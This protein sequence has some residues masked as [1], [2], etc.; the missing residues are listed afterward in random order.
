MHDYNAHSGTSHSWQERIASTGIH[1]QAIEDVVSSV[2]GDFSAPR[3][4]GILNA[5]FT[6]PAN[7]IKL[8]SGINAP[9]FLYWGDSPSPS[10]SPELRDY[11]LS[12]DLVETLRHQSGWYQP[13]PLPDARILADPESLKCNKERYAAFFR[14]REEANREREKNETSA[15]RQRRQSNLDQARKNVMPSQKNT[16]IKVFHW[17][18]DGFGNRNRRRLE[19]WEYE[20]YWDDD[21]KTKRRYDA[22][23]NEWDICSEF[24]DEECM[25][26]SG[27]YDEDDDDYDHFYDLNTKSVEPVQMQVL[28]P[29]SASAVSSP[30]PVPAST[31]VFSPPPAPV[32][33]PSPAPV[34]SPPP[35]LV[36]SPP[37]VPVSSPPPVPVSSRP[38]A[39]VSPPPP[40]PV[41]SRSPAPVPSR[42]PAPVSSPPP[43]PVSSHPPVSVSSPPP[44]PV[45][46]AL[47]SSIPDDSDTVHLQ[48]PD[49][50]DLQPMPDLSRAILLQ[51]HEPDMEESGVL[52]FIDHNISPSE[53]ARLL[54]GLNPRLVLPAVSLST[55]P[56][57]KKLRVDHDY[58]D[59]G[60]GQW[61]QMR[62]GTNQEYDLLKYEFGLMFQAPSLDD[63]LPDVV[64]LTD[65]R[66]P[67]FSRIG[68]SLK[69]V[70]D[71]V[72][73]GSPNY[74]LINPHASRG[75]ENLALKILSSQ[76]ILTIFR[77][78]WDDRGLPY[79]AC[80]LCRAGI[81]FRPCLMSSPQATPS[82]ETLTSGG[83]SGLGYRPKGY[84]LDEHDYHAYRLL[85]STFFQGS[86]GQLALYY[87][88]LV[89]RIALDFI[90]VD[91][92]LLLPELSSSSK[93]VSAA[94]LVFSWNELTEDDKHLICG[95][96]HV[97]AS[98]F[99][100]SDGL[101]ETHAHPRP[102]ESIRMAVM[103]AT[104]KFV[105]E[106]VL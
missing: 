102:S 76:D 58:P 77:R 15:D 91:L 22:F 69:L 19:K 46:V 57:S 88:G 54:F 75:F 62:W 55:P 2:C 49:D 41:S 6:E 3:L 28:P 89:A 9:I 67:V 11:A 70:C 52:E 65:R 16:K 43:A 24:E 8:L 61:N 66:A 36:S 32:F 78:K 27:S 29:L 84:R 83:Y 98:M 103:V 79:L 97:D 92:S 80:Q 10:L 100:L 31:S 17:D 101:S 73:D 14:R 12:S 25:L 44:A 34:S 74:F 106:R 30:P 40:V 71:N 95:V 48:E 39:L 47:P 85:L 96:Y 51:T 87:G 35:A 18:D 105:G 94:N 93:S 38:P 68:Q 13:P 23:R 86:R 99:D 81:A 45:S 37:P 50:Q 33:S 104:A 64:D 21:Y 59:L 82:S 26:S 90:D 4:G 42:P 1:L 60:H 20:T 5:T 72:E 7:F 56:P 53:M 63:I